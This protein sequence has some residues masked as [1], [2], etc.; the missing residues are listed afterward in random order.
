[1]V[2]SISAEQHARVTHSIHD[3]F[4]CERGGFVVITELDA[5]EET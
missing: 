4:G 1:V 2:W 3:V 5:E